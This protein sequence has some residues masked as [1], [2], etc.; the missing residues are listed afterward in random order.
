MHRKIPIFE[1]AAK[2]TS[3]QTRTAAADAHM[4]EIWKHLN[5]LLTW[6]TSVSAPLQLRTTPTA[7]SKVLAKNM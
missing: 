2:T 3:P 1:S 6:N 4:L 7:V 5:Q